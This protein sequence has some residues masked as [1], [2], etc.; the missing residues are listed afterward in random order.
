[1][2]VTSRGKKSNP[3]EIPG[4][5]AAELLEIQRRF[6]PPARR[7]RLED[8]GL[9]AG[10]PNP[11]RERIAEFDRNC[12]LRASASVNTSAAASEQIQ[13]RSPSGPT[14]RPSKPASESKSS[15]PGSQHTG[16]VVP[17]ASLASSTQ[18]VSADSGSKESPAHPFL[19]RV[20]PDAHTQPTPTPPDPSRPSATQNSGSQGQ[21]ESR[22]ASQIC[23]II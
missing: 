2:N 6:E 7:F 3:T 18:V 22:P 13:P 9:L 14:Q 21:S 19:N 1:M 20:S 15:A 11:I 8:L 4:S 23:A 12:A 16:K 10:P 17:T 5:E